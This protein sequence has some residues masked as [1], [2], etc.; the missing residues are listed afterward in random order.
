MSTMGSSFYANC[1]VP[2]EPSEH[3]KAEWRPVWLEPASEETEAGPGDKICCYFEV[4]VCHFG[5]RCRNRHVREDMILVSRPIRPHSSGKWPWSIIS[6]YP[7]NAMPVVEPGIFDDADSAFFVTLGITPEPSD[8]DDLEQIATPLP[9]ADK[10][11]DQRPA[12]LRQA[13][14][15]RR[16]I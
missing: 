4:G 8:S 1:E 11:Y 13:T 6:H 14:A 9:F 5:R 3:R 10:P 7:A 16:P 12:W 2:T 15:K